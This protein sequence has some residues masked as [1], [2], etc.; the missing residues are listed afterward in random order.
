MLTIARASLSLSV[1][2]DLDCCASTT[3]IHLTSF[4]QRHFYYYIFI[5]Y[6]RKTIQG[7]DWGRSFKF[8]REWSQNAK[9]V[10]DKPGAVSTMSFSF[11]YDVLSWKKPRDIF[12]FCF[13]LDSLRLRIQTFIALSCL[14][15]R[16]GG[17]LAICLF[18]CFSQKEG[19]GRTP[20]F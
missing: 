13:L 4:L 6:R 11:C 18:V 16:Y 1:I 20:V 3:A 5:H 17:K 12:C 19:T 15:I 14:V 9:I 8:C 10:N 2:K 7:N